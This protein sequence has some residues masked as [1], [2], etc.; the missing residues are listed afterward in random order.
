M[1]EKSILAKLRA[2]IKDYRLSV[3]GRYGSKQLST[4]IK[5]GLTMVWNSPG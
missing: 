5:M 1:L 4:G 2:E 3:H